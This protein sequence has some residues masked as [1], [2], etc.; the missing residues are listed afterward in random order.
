MATYTPEQEAAARALLAKGDAMGQAASKQTGV[1][2]APQY[3]SAPYQAPSGQATYN[4]PAA[5]VSYTP[6]PSTA[7][8]T[9]AAT[10]GNLEA[11]GVGMYNNLP[12]SRDA[13]GDY[14]TFDF[15]TNQK[16]SYGTTLPGGTQLSTYGKT[17][18]DSESAPKQTPTQPTTNTQD[19]TVPSAATTTGTQAGTQSNIQTGQQA[20]SM[21]NSGA[22]TMN[23]QGSIID[24]LNSVGV[25]S[26]Q[27]N[28]KLLA[29]QYGVQNYDF[30]AAK[31]TELAN[32]YIA[33]YN[34]T[35]GGAAPDS[36]AAAR[37]ATASAVQS[38]VQGSGD[39]IAEFYDSYGSMDPITAA[40]FQQIAAVD[41]QLS[42]QRLVSDIW[43]EEANKYGDLGPLKKQVAE[44]L[45]DERMTDEQVREELSGGGGLVLESQVRGI[46]VIRSKALLVKAEMLSNIINGAEEAADR[47]VKLTQADRQQVNDQ[48]D[49]KLGL[50]KLLADHTMQ[51]QDR[52]RENY[53][54]I[55]EDVNYDGLA[56]MLAGSPNKAREAEKALGLSFGTLSNP[57]AVQF[58]SSANEKKEK[59]Q[60]IGSSS[61]GYY[62]VSFDENGNPTAVPIIGGTGGGEGGYDF[63]KTQLNK[64]ANNAN[65]TV[66]KFKALDPEVQNFYVNLSPTAAS[67]L[68]TDF[69][70]V[71]SGEQDA[72]E[73]KDSI[74]EFGLSGEVETYLIGEI[75]RRAPADQPS[76]WDKVKSWIGL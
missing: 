37:A 72:D 31:N 22:L 28:R 40:L 3:T 74:R 27:A 67:A 76:T 38:A 41:S 23:P 21:A 34:A 7:S 58:L 12:L 6:S 48:L 17:L 46:A 69:A 19:T 53:R 43:N 14:Y 68:K 32:K 49:R 24:L 51:M 50:T 71:V 55:I 13:S 47:V 4:N 75:D 11:Q 2:Y 66:D 70:N 36:A 45:A 56:Q 33:A 62:A 15:N 20:A 5:P 59:P 30:S 63:T 9:P 16:V 73:A 29:Q 39:P 18:L 52:A 60:I 1:A 10:T 35:K 8:S 44:L 61:G 64:G 26:S 25:D 65:L 54:Q 42:N 57:N